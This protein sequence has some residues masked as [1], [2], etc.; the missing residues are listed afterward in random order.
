MP[1]KQ[2]GKKI[3]EVA[4]GRVVGKS[5]SV[6][7]AKAAARIRNAAHFAKMKGPKAYAEFKRSFGD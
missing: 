3:V 7:K 1:V 2:V 4:T 5:K 6:K